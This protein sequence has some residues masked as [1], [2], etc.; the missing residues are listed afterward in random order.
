[1]RYLLD[2][3]SFLWFIAGDEQMSEKA[4]HLIE[5]VENDI[6]L[7][8]RSLWEMSIKM[9]LGKLTFS[10]P[11]SEIIPQQIKQNSIDL[12]PIAMQDMSR[13]VDLPF[14]HRDPFDR[15]IIVQ[16]MTRNIPVIGDDAE[17]SNYPVELVW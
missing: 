11:F 8:V 17:F 3:H 12:M 4:R 16:A 10:R 1:M 14:H 15:L 5:D 9:S 6:D 2:T 7:S 13:L